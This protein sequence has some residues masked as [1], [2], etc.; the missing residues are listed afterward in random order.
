MTNAI[1]TAIL[2]SVFTFAT[3][4]GV[5]FASAQSAGNPK[6]STE[7]G[8]AVGRKRL[9]GADECAENPNNPDCLGG[10]VDG[11]TDRRRPVVN[12]DDS[13]GDRMQ[14]PRRRTAER[15]DDWRY[16]RDRH[17]RRRSRNAQFRFYF[18]GFYYPE[19][20]WQGFGVPFYSD[21]ISCSYGRRA[22]ADRGYRRVRTIECNGRNY[23]YTARRNG[24]VY[25]IVISARTGNIVSRREI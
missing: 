19:A 16:D 9:K 8:E 11:G 12:L 24:N 17:D 6:V 2:A 18:D 13:D 7:A 5:Q 25:R 23:T 3:F 22:V 15:R 10:R 21:R 1:R 20:Y 14:K 4:G